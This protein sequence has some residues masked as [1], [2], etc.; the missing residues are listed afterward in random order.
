MKN[1][2]PAISVILVNYKSIQLTVDC[3]DSIRSCNTTVPYEIIVI[4]NHSQDD[5]VSELQK[6]FPDVAVK[7]SGRNGGFAFGNNMG[8]RLAKGKYL[9]LLNNDTEVKDGMLNALYEFAEKN[10]DVGMLGCRAMDRNGVEL[11]VMHQYETLRRIWLQSNVKPTLENLGIQRAMVKLF[12][13]R[14]ESQEVFTTAEWIAGSAMFIRRDLYYQIGGLDE[15]Y[16]MYMEDE[17]LCHRLNDAGY[18][19]GII[20]FLGYVHYCGGSTIQSYFLTK[21]YIRSRLIFF[22]RY[23]PN[24]F[25][26]IKKALYHQI[27]AVNKNITKYQI[28][29]MKK[30]LDTFVE[31]DLE[32]L[33][34]H[35]NGVKG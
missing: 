33:A 8:V 3:I 17:D 18:K 34:Q 10:P 7:D 4:D 32:C 15:N 24:Q 12:E 27:T 20:P 14:K 25:E 31:K 35:I 16:F 2:I 22:K 26:R 1:H 23:D 13:S 21:E 19:V 5:C 11:P 28:Q 6:K 29:E 9:L 30:E